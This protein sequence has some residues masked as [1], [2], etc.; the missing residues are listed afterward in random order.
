MEAQLEIDKLAEDFETD[1]GR[2][3][4]VDGGTLRQE[5]G[6]TQSQ[7]GENGS[8]KRDTAHSIARQLQPP[9]RRKPGSEP[10]QEEIR[11]LKKS[12]KPAPE[13]RV[14]EKPI[15][16]TGGMPQ[17]EKNAK[18]QAA[19]PRQLE[20]EEPTTAMEETNQA[21]KLDQLRGLQRQLGMAILLNTHKL[22]EEAGKTEDLAVKNA[23]PGVRSARDWR[24]CGEA[25]CA[26]GG[27]AITGGS[28]VR[29]RVSQAVSGC[30]SGPV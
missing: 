5:E 16:H 22:A 24:Q 21:R 23:G 7:E 30:R 27:C 4:E 10:R 29:Q 8:G 28:S 15:Q 17:R 18:A 19:R 3:R 6:R 13:Q 2:E 20:A 11:K 12:G 25:A 14:R 26:G 1:T 9:R